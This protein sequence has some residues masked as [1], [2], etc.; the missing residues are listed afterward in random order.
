MALTG[1]SVIRSLTTLFHGPGPTTSTLALQL[2]MLSTRQEGKDSLVGQ[3]SAQQPLCK[4][5]NTHTKE[6]PTGATGLYTAHSDRLRGSRPASQLL[7]DHVG[8]S[9]TSTISVST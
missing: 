8:W 2:Y 7:K 5:P 6:M 4:H 9:Q 1:D 3:A